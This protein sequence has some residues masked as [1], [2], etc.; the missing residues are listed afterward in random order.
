MNGTHLTFLLSKLIHREKV[1][2]TEARSKFSPKSAVTSDAVNN[3]DDKIFSN[4]RI[5]NKHYK[6]VL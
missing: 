4:D 1:Q 3:S 2:G 5:I 6:T